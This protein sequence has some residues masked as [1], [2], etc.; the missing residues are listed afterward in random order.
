MK[1]LLL[2]MATAV[3]REAMGKPFLVEEIEMA[4]F[5]K[6]RY[7][8]AIR[9]YRADPGDS[10]PGEAFRLIMRDMGDE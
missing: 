2:Q 4:Y 7:N 10:I 5:I 1:P 8:R 9:Q 3:I 6:T